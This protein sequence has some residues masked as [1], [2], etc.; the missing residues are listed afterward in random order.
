MTVIVLEIPDEVN[1]LVPAMREIVGAVKRQVERGRMGAS[2]D[3]AEF[4]RDPNRRRLSR[5]ANVDDL[6]RAARRRLPRG[7]FDYI[8]GAAEGERTLQRNVEAFA[9]RE[10]VPRVLRDV[11]DIDTTTQLLGRPLPLP[12]VLAPTGFTRIAHSRAS[13]RKGR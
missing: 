4:E 1:A 13:S 10:L 5:V 7:V 3:V 6:R 11:S 8:D 9:E 12:L 2:T